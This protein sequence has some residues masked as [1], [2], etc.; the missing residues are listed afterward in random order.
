MTAAVP[1][2]Q[3]SSSLPWRGG[4]GDFVDRHRP[5]GDAEPP[6]AHQGQHRVARH[7]GQDRAAERRR[8]DLVAD[9]QHDVHRADLVDVL[10]LAAVEPQHLREPVVLG[11]FSGVEA[12][13]VVDAGLGA[14]HAALHRA[15]VLVD[16]EDL[17]RVHAL[18]VIGADRRQD[19]VVDVGLRRPHA[20]EGLVGDDRGPHVERG[21]D[22]RR[23]PVLLH[24]D[25]GHQR[26]QR[27]LGIERRDAETARGLDQPR[28]VLL[29]PEEP[30]LA[31]AR[32]ER[33]EP[34]EDRLGV[35]EHRRR[36]VHRERPVRLDP[37]IVPALLFLE[38]HHEHVIG[39]DGSERELAV[40]RLRL[41]HRRP[42]DPDWLT[43]LIPSPLEFLLL[44]HLG[45]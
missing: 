29:R 3:T 12:R 30:D 15:H 13:R 10:A 19:H 1:V 31:V 45:G 26:L 25:Q 32:A 7:A 14:A 34:V 36:R 8:D 28:D 24:S 39:E 40:L 38:V 6:L 44:L 35:V 20:E 11:L 23:H 4:G 17:H 33:L 21:P 18:G 43:H 37:R 41:L 42:A 9:L 16:H 5:L 27:E 2:P 22:R